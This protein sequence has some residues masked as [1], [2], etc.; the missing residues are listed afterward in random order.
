MKTPI[1]ILSVF[2]ILM[3]GFNAQT[4]NNSF[5]KESEHNLVPDSNIIDSI[6][7]LECECYNRALLIEDSYKMKL[8]GLNCYKYLANY[9][10]S[11][12]YTDYDTEQ[13]QYFQKAM[14]DLVG[15]ITYHNCTS[16]S[17]FFS[18]LNE[19]RETDPYL[20]ENYE[21][22]EIAKKG[23][24]ISLEIEDSILLTIC[25]DYV[26]TDFKD[27]GYYSLSTIEWIDEFS[28]YE[29][30]ME[31]DHPFYFWRTKHD[32]IVV[33]TISIRDSIIEYDIISK[34]LTY[35]G[36]IKRIN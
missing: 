33:N 29:I 26:R 2:L 28:Y 25:D 36:V 7:A 31:T 13:V 1:I 27:F 11:K 22:M 35:P 8:H 30:F 15:E 20:I 18:T 5:D 23:T 21:L 9:L 10:T 14:Y 32:T 16:F 6:A 19:K 34:F 24:F 12:N 17:D 3:L 4:F